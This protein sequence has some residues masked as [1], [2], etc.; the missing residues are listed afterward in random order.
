MRLRGS[1]SGNCS[2]CIRKILPK[3]LCMN[4]YNTE[5]NSK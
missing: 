5:Y 2:K 1:E 3:K 4:T